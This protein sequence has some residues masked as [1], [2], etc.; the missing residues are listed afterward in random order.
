[1]SDP[2]RA[3]LTDAIIIAARAHHGQTDKA[4]EPYILHP[5]RVMGMMNTEDSRIVAVLHD[6]LE[7][8]PWT[9]DMLDAEGFS[10]EQVE[11][12]YVLTR[13]PHEHYTT[14]IDRVAG[15]TLTRAVKLADL[16]DNLD[17]GRLAR[18]PF[19]VRARLQA[20]YKAAQERL[21]YGDTP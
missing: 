10:E 14:Y 3:T 15:D 8:T 13:R 9:D 12:I 21:L 19:E 16:A 18:L 7:D 17:P 5:L 11:A 20:K 4:G 6:V 1:M 2:K